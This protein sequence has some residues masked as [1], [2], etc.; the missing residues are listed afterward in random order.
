L[1]ERARPEPDETTSVLFVNHASL[2]VKKADQYLLTD[3]WHQ[4]PAF[5]SWLPTFP[6]YV[7]PTYFAALGDKLSILI[8]HGHD[9]HCDD[10][11]LRIFD[12][13][14]EI[15]T[16][17]FNAPSV[18]NRLRKLGFTNIK[19]TDSNGLTLKS[20]FT[21]KSYVN[22]ERSL[23]DATYSID[24][25]S[26]FV[27]HCNDNWFEFDADTLSRIGNDRAR[28]A[29]E[30]IAFFS[31]TNS[32][33]GHPLSYKIFDDR[34][35]I[36]ILRSKVKGMVVQGMKNADALGLNSFY[37]Y[38]GFASVFVK[39]MPAYLELGL[40]PT[41]KFIRDELLDDA[42]SKSLLGRVN[43]RDLYPGDVLDLSDGKITKAFIS[44]AD[45]ADG[46]LKDA[47]VRYYDTY[48]IINH[49]DTY[50]P[51]TNEKFDQDRFF[52][53]LENLNEFVGRKIHADAKS[54]DT[55]VGKSLEIVILDLNVIGTIV[56]GGEVYLG[57]RGRG[58]PNKRI[59]VHSSLMS[60]VLYGEIL[61]ENLYTGYEAQWE[62]FPSDVYNRDIVMFVV[63]YSYVYKNRLAKT[64]LPLRAPA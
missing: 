23:D 52:Y 27:V 11:L 42:E 21:I 4:R 60:Q 2:L 41:A 14:T 43:V 3:P 29:N 19:T 5:G 53:F 17:A 24:T 44:S 38:A 25:G 30:N 15:V 16:A 47:T 9:D 54:F 20:G 45:Y 58:Q 63:M 10:D 8:S 62:R 33:S 18:L 31:Q 6:Q 35:K 64:A 7:H 36:S 51:A 48:G 55:I 49:C 40:I 34:Q 28:Y 61:F 59:T 1:I 32:A 13:D 12:K 39:G 50:K 46:R 57:A 37:S 22:P 26:G 56:F